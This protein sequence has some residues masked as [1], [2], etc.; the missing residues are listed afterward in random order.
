MNNVLRSLV[1]LL[2]LIAVGSAIQLS[3]QDEVETTQILENANLAAE[4]V[5][6]NI[7]QRLEQSGFVKSTNGRWQFSTKQLQQKVSRLPANLK[8]Q[9]YTW[10]NQHNLEI[11]GS[12]TGVDLNPYFANSYLVGYKPFNTKSIWQ[13]LATIALRKTYVLDH[14]LYGPKFSEIW[15]N[16]RQAYAYTR[17]DCEDHAIILADWLIAMGHNARVVL[18]KYKNGGHAWVVLFKNNKEYILEATSKRRPRSLSDFRIA[19]LATN[20]HPVYQFDRHR[21][22]VN[23]GSPLTTHYRDKK[24]QLRSTFIR[25]G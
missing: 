20:Y 11:T 4:K 23:T 16:S 5:D 17:G 25:Q 18:G 6:L 19:A 7:N 12:A 22:W 3:H 10:S 24:W 8:H 9:F 1:W 2:I 13:P 15:Q 21:F 14:D